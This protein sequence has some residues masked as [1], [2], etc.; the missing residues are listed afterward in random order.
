MNKDIRYDV[1]YN[2]NGQFK[3]HYRAKNVRVLEEE[4]DLVVYESDAF[5]GKQKHIVTKVKYIF[6]PVIPKPEFYIGQYI[7]ISLK[8]EDWSYSDCLF[9]IT[10]FEWRNDCYEYTVTSEKYS[11][12]KNIKLNAKMATFVPVSE[13]LVNSYFGR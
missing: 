1:R 5:Y 11:W 13:K 6:E 7:H 3:N 2:N 10:G 4:G 9:Q 12:Y 8:N